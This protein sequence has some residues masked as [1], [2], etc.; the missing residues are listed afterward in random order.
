MNDGRPHLPPYEKRPLNAPAALAGVRVLD[1]SRMI[2]GPYG[3]MLLGD[4]GAD[5]IKLENPESGDD[6]RALKPPSLGGESA[7]F[8]WANR[9]KR[10]IALDLRIPEAQLVARNLARHADVVVESFSA[11]I[12]ER[13]GLSYDALSRDN[14]KLIYCSVSGFGRSGS[15]ASRP[16]YDPILQAESGFMSMNGFPDQDPVRAGPSVVDIVSGMMVSNAVLAA[17]MARTKHGIGQMVEVSLFDCAMTLNGQYAMN[18]LMTG[19][20]QKRFGNGSMTAEPV[21]LFNAADGPI[22]IT[23]A[24]NKN[25]QCLVVDVMGQPELASDPDFQSNA[26]R[27]QH[28]EKLRKNLARIFVQQPRRAWL[29]RGRHAG[30]PIGSIRSIAEAFQSAEARERKLATAIPH[31]EAGMVPNIAPPFRLSG[32]PV[33]DPVA[34]P[35]LGQHTAQVLE[36]ILACGSKEL[37]ALSGVGAFGRGRNGK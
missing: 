22:Y 13:F 26:L 24:N 8:L 9:N 5:V 1:F 3:T 25:F 37:D 36:E 2:A 35:A 17:L 19:E 20:E 21:G 4:L 6:A 16:G 23:C 11:G 29:E 30:V 18:Y 7:V 10:S 34:P 12:M 15:F 31:P 28:R 27:C 14:P 32:T 33:V